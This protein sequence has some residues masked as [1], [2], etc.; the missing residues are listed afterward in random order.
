MFVQ[1]RIAFL[2]TELGITDAQA[3][4][5]DAYAEAMKGN[6]VNM[7]G[8]RQAMRAA[9]DAETPVARLD[10]HI[11]VLESRAATLKAMQKPLA[12]LYAALSEAQKQKAN[13]LMT[14]MGCMM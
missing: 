5:W 11:G 1:G 7:Q 8:L 13:D 4:V 10:A 14:G 9:F 2:K 6:F 12:D 3:P